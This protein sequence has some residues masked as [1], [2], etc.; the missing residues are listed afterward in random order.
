MRAALHWGRTAWILQNGARY[1]G[2]ARLFATDEASEEALNASVVAKGYCKLDAHSPWCAPG[3]PRPVRVS[4]VSPLC[5]IYLQK[6]N[7]AD[8]THYRLIDG[9][10]GL[11]AGTPALP[12]RSIARRARSNQSSSSS[13]SGEPVGR[14]KAACTGGGIA[15]LAP[16]TDC[17][18]ISL[19]SSS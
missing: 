15:G 4:M 6:R 13:P 17:Q 19:S 2:R 16:C 8:E 14:T 1:S 5:D 10:D 9:P 12:F 11:G 18:R 3:P 7:L